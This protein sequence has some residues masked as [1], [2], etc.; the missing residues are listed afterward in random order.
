MT[1]VHVRTASLEYSEG[2]LHGLLVPLNV[3]ARVADVLPDGNLDIYD[4]GFRA[5]VFDR[6]LTGDT[7]LLRR[8]GFWHT[9]D[10]ND[11]AGYFGPASSLEQRDDGIHGEFRILT[12]KRADL[13]D[14]MDEGIVDL[15]IEFKERFDGT[16]I[17]DEGVRW[18]TSAHLHGVALDAR[19]AYPG[20]EVLA[21]RSIDELV[22]ERAE[23]DAAEAEAV[24]AAE[25]A[26]LERQQVD[27]AQAEL[28]RRQRDIEEWFAA[29]RAR[30]VS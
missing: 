24:A 30:C 15:S 7:S 2:Q 10:H 5:G 4:E 20:A 9:H 6:Q 19:G 13:R 1:T 14:L 16:S 3:R 26:E 28:Q 17:D 18:R 27:E 12:S 11:G 23:R 21:Y 22:E 29:E 25:A 8:I